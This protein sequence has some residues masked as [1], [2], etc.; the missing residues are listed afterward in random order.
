MSS[1][2]TSN[3]QVL[4]E[5]YRKSDNFFDSDLIFTHIYRRDISEE[6]HDYL[7][8]KLDKLG[9]EAA[10]RM[11]E[12]SL[13]ADKNSPELVK[14]NFYGEDINEI[15]FHPA[16]ETLKEIAIHSGMFEVKWRPDLRRQ[17]QSEI[18][19]MGFAPGFLYALSEIGLY[20]PLCMTDGV[21]RL[22]D[23]YCLE[24]DRLR[25][26]PHIYTQNPVELFTGAMFLTEKAGGSDVGTNIVSA[27]HYKDRY[28]QLNGEKWFCSNANAEIIFALARTNSEVKGTKG[29]SIFLVE[30]QRPDGSK[31]EMDVVRLKDK[32]GVRSMASA[33][34]ILTDTIGKLVGEEGEGFKIMTDMIN[35]SRLYNAVSAIGA[36]RRALIEAY[37]FLKY[38]VSFG[39][40]ALS[41]ALI[42]EKLTELGA[43]HVANFYLTWRTIK[44]LD[45]SDNGDQRESDLVRLLTPMV[46]KGTAAYCVY[47]IR[48]S[49]ELM[50]GIGYIEDGVVPKVMRDAMV[51]PIWEGAGNIM[52]LDMLRA[53]SKSLGFPILCEE[54]EK[55]I[56]GTQYESLLKNALHE[57]V[58]LFK[59]FK[60]DGQEEVEATAKPLFERLTLLFQIAVLYEYLDD[61]S[62]P[63]INPAIDYLVE[64]VQGSPLQKK[65]P[66]PLEVVESMMGWAI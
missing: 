36:A 58:T 22:I 53:A 29:L 49:M 60:E 11:N 20:C 31:N 27:K 7:N 1:N 12:L 41:H 63:W 44:A 8:L 33:E 9:E 26:L 45:H 35:L 19:R 16:Y 40:P 47:S 2:L 59:S 62:N 64:Q 42:R 37:Q 23:R 14:R 66:L 25:L 56:T 38:R 61:Q 39:K 13:L 57:V 48:E 4:Q 52:T 21:A 54:I 24:E 10:G 5:G 32:L 34:C 51:L 65:K 28:Y 18:H 55:Q 15:N 6:G 30:K 50:G 17:F 46:K 3:N 43:L